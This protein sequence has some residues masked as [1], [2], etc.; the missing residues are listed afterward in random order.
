M[1][2]IEALT[3]DDEIAALFSDDAD[4]KAMLD[5]EAALAHTQAAAGL[6]PEATAR[7]IHRACAGFQPDWELLAKGIAKDGMVVPELIRQLRK[8][9]GEP[10]AGFVHLRATSQDVIDTSLMLRLKV[11]LNIFEARLDALVA[12]LKNLHIR[13]CAIPLMAHTRM[14]QALPFTAADK[15]KTWIEPLTRV[16]LRLDDLKPRL[17]VIQFGGPIGTRNGLDGKGEAIAADL[18]DRLGLGMAPPWHSERDRI[19]EL[20]AWLSQLSGALGKLGQDVALMTQNELEAVKLDSSG[21][22]SSMPHKSN[23]VAAEV[24]VALARLNAGLLGTLHQSLVHENERS[25]AAWTLEWLVLP[26]MVVATGAGLRHA[27][28]LSV[29][30]KFTPHHSL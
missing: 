10:H 30:L 24:L 14:Q 3:G 13:D 18:A 19:A 12:T 2:L 20:G 23:P 5:F 7:A 9:A 15:L 4:L 17:L 29:G 25:G 27:K 8:A 22:S 28:S 16:R 11:V 6:F 26:R 21:G 1:R